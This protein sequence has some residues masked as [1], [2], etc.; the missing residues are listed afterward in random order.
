MKL[1]LQK[2]FK[3]ISEVLPTIQSILSED[4]E[5]MVYDKDKGYILYQIESETDKSYE[6]ELFEKVMFL[7]M[8]EMPSFSILTL[9]KL[10][11][12]LDEDELF[13]THVLTGDSKR[14][15]NHLGERECKNLFGAKVYENKELPEDTT[16]LV[17][18]DKR[19]AYI[20]DFKIA[21]KVHT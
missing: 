7:E 10:T 17:I 2:K 20:P 14:L 9:F 6:Q 13:L 16:L 11:C 12:A 8:K 19:N 18:S 3:A 1:N 21:L 4:P 15:F 5:R